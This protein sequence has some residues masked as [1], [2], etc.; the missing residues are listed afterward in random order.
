MTEQIA[1]MLGHRYEGCTVVGKPAMR[2]VNSF[3]MSV[4]VTGP[5]KIS[6]DPA[7]MPPLDTHNVHK[8]IERLR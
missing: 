8:A 5:D 6:T 7:S 1:F 4:P 2:G 3:M